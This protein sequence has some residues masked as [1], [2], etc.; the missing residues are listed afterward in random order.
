MILIIGPDDSL[1]K[2]SWW[3]A[4]SILSS[5]QKWSNDPAVGILYFSLGQITHRPRIVHGWH[6]FCFSQMT[7]GYW[8]KLP[9]IP[10]PISNPSSIH[11]LHQGMYEVTHSASFSGPLAN[12]NERELYHH[13]GFCK[14][15]FAN[16]VQAYML[17]TDT[18]LN[19]QAYLN[20]LATC[21]P[22]NLQCFKLN[23]CKF[24]I[25]GLPATSSEK[26]LLVE[27]I[28]A[29]NV[30]L[31][32]SLTTVFQKPTCYPLTVAMRQDLAHIPALIA[33]SPV[34]LTPDCWHPWDNLY[35]FAVKATSKDKENHVASFYLQAPS[36]LLPPSV[37]LPPS[38]DLPVA[39]TMPTPVVSLSCIRADALDWT[40][41]SS[42]TTVLSARS[43]VPKHPH[44]PGQASD[45]SSSN[46]M[47]TYMEQNTLT[48]GNLALVLDTDN[49]DDHCSHSI[50][51]RFTR[52]QL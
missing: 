15:T 9:G 39:P 2:W 36:T 11:D 21:L 3:S 17:V 51:W 41:D 23:N 16:S 46:D 5:G 52:S 20:Q 14:G 24:N 13:V 27:S 40:S 44:S 38:T 28:K 30:I 26:S 48:F 37:L 12:D 4:V 7:N 42:D 10:Q 8:T 32:S 18:E 6:T 19:C 34:L 33:Y 47:D 29:K 31:N 45:A 49:Q 35:C 50:L 25:F 22:E 43:P 1:C